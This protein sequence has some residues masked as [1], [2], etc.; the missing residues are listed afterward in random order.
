MGVDAMLV[1]E[2]LVRAGDIGAKVRELVQAV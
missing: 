2:T 1:G